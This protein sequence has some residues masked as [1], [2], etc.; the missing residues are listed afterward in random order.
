MA[1]AKKEYWKP[2]V[3]ADIVPVN[4]S[5]AQYRDDGA[6]VNV[7]LIKRSDKS[8]AYPNCW[9]FPGGFLDKGESIEQCAERELK[10]ETG[11]VATTLLPIGVFSNPDRD[12][13]GQVISN[14]FL[15]V[16]ASTPDQPLQMKASD[17]AKE[18]GLFKIK[19]QFNEDKGTL[20][21]NMKCVATGDEI[22]F[23]TKFSRG[24]FGAIETAIE[25]VKG[26][27]YTELA[28]DHAEILAR[29]ILKAPDL[30]LPTKTKPVDEEVSKKELAEHMAKENGK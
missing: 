6:I 9:A 22:A 8:E 3:T 23:A 20:D 7:I 5:A 14:A 11:L 15:S 2:S 12:P 10:E 26:Q 18:I 24:K 21:I 13:R 29:T 16:F 4:I 28:F 19:G 17:D 30:I 27:N 25:Y 1:E